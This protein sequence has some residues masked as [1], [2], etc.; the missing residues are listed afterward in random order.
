M[1]LQQNKL[2]KNAPAVKDNEK[3]RVAKK[4]LLLLFFMII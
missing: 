3:T 2:F 1:I 4:E